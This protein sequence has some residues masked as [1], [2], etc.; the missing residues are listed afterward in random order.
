MITDTF[1]QYCV[2]KIFQY[3]KCSAT[4]D[5]QNEI[6]NSK[7]DDLFVKVKGTNRG[8]CN[9]PNLYDSQYELFGISKYY[10]SRHFTNE[11]LVNCP[12]G[13]NYCTNIHN[14]SDDPVW[15]AQLKY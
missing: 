4:I 12:F 15:I 5:C 9:R 2:D 14:S 6:D 11:A 1:L 13:V 7:R 3:T 8:Q 10:M